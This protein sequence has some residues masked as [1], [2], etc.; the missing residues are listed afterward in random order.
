[1][2]FFVER[3][4]TYCALEQFLL[5]LG[6][7]Q[8]VPFHILFYVE[9]LTTQGALERFFSGMDPLVSASALGSIKSF[10]TDLALIRLFPS[11]DQFV[12]LKKIWKLK[13]T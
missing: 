4:I 1:M 8:H 13:V 11:V 5:L 10:V 6:M 9:R 12:M 7:G 2:G 3:L